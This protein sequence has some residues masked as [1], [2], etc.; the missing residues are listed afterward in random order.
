M[1]K[2]INKM[3]SHASNL[4]NNIYT[5]EFLSAVASVQCRCL[6]FVLS[7]VM[8]MGI[9][10]GHASDTEFFRHADCSCKSV[11]SAPC[12]SGQAYIEHSSENHSFYHAHFELQNKAQSTI[13]IAFL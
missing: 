13:Y 10:S 5:T 12:G 6:L 1:E 2:E 9:V 11:Y 3:Y 8:C 4:V 7:V